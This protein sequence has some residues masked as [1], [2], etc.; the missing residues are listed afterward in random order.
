MCTCLAC[1]TA[2]STSKGAQYIIHQAQLHD[3]L[4][5]AISDC[6]VSIAFTRWTQGQPASVQG[7]PRLLKH[8]AVQHI[9]TLHY[10]QPD[11]KTP[12]QAQH[13]PASQTRSTVQDHL[14]EAG[15]D[16]ACTRHVTKHCQTA[17][18]VPQDVDSSSSSSSSSTSMGY[19]ATANSNSAETSSKASS[20]GRMALVFGREEFGLT[21]EEIAACSV[22]C[23]ISIGRLQVSVYR[24]CCMVH[25]MLHVDN[26]CVL[27][28]V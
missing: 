27:Y 7:I 25:S 18:S 16:S 1:S 9:Q 13:N 19:G 21:D 11:R 23:S 8:P 24:Q 3:T 15:I 17:V 12:Q 20:Q 26:R 2:L 22:A 6:D 4:A 5:D 28:C 10:W 14:A